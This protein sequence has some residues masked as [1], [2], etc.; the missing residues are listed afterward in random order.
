MKKFELPEGSA[1]LLNARLN[2]PKVIV[3]GVCIPDNPTHRVPLVGKR[4][5]SELSIVMLLAISVPSIDELDI[6]K[7]AL[8]ANRAPWTWELVI[9]ME[10]IKLMSKMIKEGCTLTMLKAKLASW[11]FV[12]LMSCLTWINTRVLGFD[13]S[14][15]K[16]LAWFK[17]DRGTEKAT[18]GKNPSAFGEEC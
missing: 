6:V 15:L 8:G 10:V 1:T 7:F 11:R 17:M 5:I 13:I 4:L 12:E 2:P 9:S 3:W 16:A 18:T 14:K